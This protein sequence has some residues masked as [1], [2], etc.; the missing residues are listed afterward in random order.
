MNRR[1][2]LKGSIASLL[3]GTLSSNKVLASTINALTP[4]S[5]NVLLYLI[6]NKNGDW[7]I[8]G[9]KWTNIKTAR[10]SQFEYDLNTFKPLTIVDN[11]IVN[12]V[13][14]KYWKEYNCKGK[15]PKNVNYLSS[16]KS[17]LKAKQSGQWAEALKKSYGAS[18]RMHP[19]YWKEHGSKIGK[20]NI[21]S[22][23][24]SKLHQLYG[25]DLGNKWGKIG[26]KKVVDNKLGIHSASKEQRK[27]WASIGGKAGGKA[28]ALKYDMKVFSK[29]GNE[30]N[31]KKYGKKV[32]AHNIQT[33]EVKMFDS[34]GQAERYCDI[35]SV[36]VRKILRGLQPKTRCGWTF[37][38]Q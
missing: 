21:E 4:E 14:E 3:L 25:K 1:S 9:T 38:Y 24:L 31:I 5:L 6:Q 12:D 35:Q 23:H 13:K 11:I 7:K 17:G 26:A 29:L 37:N 8:K 20:Q 28:M 16:Y 19:Q 22:G 34:I 36:V 30:A 32:F 2:F 10:L 18:H 15:C 33:S 27:E